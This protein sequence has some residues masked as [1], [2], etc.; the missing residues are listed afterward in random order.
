MKKLSLILSILLSFAFGG[1]LS[2]ESGI[3]KAH[4]EVFG[5]DTIDPIFRK[6]S[7]KLT[8]DKNIESIRGNVLVEMKN[9]MS[10]NSKRDEHM[11]D[12]LESKIF[13]SASLNVQEIMPKGG[14]NYAIKGNLLLHGVTKP[15]IFQGT[16]VQNGKTVHIKAKDSIK[17]SSFGIKPPKM[18]MLTVR[19]QVDL[20]VDL[21]L[22]R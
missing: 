9:F 17:M 6:V 11:Q 4:T 16:I 3:I 22:K 21:L 20:S 10:D 18:V 12:A 19:D 2:F 7:S 15:V 13:P 5:D 1:S 8:I 14:D